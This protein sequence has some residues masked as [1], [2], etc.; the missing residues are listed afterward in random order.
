[1]KISFLEK[2]YKIVKPLANLALR[3]RERTQINKVKDEKENAIRSK[4][5]QRITGDYFKY[6]H[7]PNLERLEEMHKL[8]GAHGLPE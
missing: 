5:I 1:M 4:R 7:S 2:L 8:L 6:V 3:M